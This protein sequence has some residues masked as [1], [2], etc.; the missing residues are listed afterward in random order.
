MIQS[1]RLSLARHG[2][3]PGHL[4]FPT[5]LPWIRQDHKVPGQ[6]HW[7]QVSKLSPCLLL[8]VVSFSSWQWPCHLPSTQKM[9]PEWH[10]GK[11][12]RDG[13][14][15]HTHPCPQQQGLR[16]VVWGWCWPSLSE[17]HY[18]PLCQRHLLVQCVSLQSWTCTKD[19]KSFPLC[20][21]M[22][23]GSVC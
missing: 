2:L 7:P 9:L 21:F 18:I 11:P 10:P 15:I 3:S 8:M 13:A 16:E 22:P 20:E 23:M 6:H 19:Q 12:C 5:Q 14:E 4:C 17:K 1:E